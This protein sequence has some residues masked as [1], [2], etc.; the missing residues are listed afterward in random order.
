MV[1]GG[2]RKRR[3]SR[4]REVQTGS[5][6]MKT[7]E[8]FK[9]DKNVDSQTPQPNKITQVKPGQLESRITIFLLCF[10]EIVCTFPRY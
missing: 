10:S 9:R 6:Q 8:Q 5:G 4:D 3:G 1:V 7:N 2:V